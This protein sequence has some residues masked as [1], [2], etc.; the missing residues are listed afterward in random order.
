M[1]PQKSP[2]HPQKSP[3]YLQKSPMY[4]PKEP[5]DSTKAPCASSKEPWVSARVVVCERQLVDGSVGVHK[6][7]SR[8]LYRQESCRWH[9]CLR[10]T[11]ESSSR[12]SFCHHLSQT[13]THV[14][15]DLFIDRKVVGDTRV[16]RETDRRSKTS[17][18]NISRYLIVFAAAIGP[19]N[20]SHPIAAAAY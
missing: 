12:S 6:R 5:Y 19:T 1:I 14:S 18:A 20:R 13:F 9:T 8:L 11:I 16:L 4:P 15:R 10:K 2:M 3:V 7:R 17:F